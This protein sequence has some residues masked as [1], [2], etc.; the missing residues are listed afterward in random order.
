[1]TYRPGLMTV[2]RPVSGIL[3]AVPSPVQRGGH[4]SERSTW[5]DR[6]GRPSH[7]LT[8]LRVGFAK[9]PGS[10]RALVRS[11]RTVSP[12]PVADNRIRWIRDVSPSAVCF[13]WHF[14]ASHLDWPLASTLPCGVPT[15]LDQVAGVSAAAWPRP[16]GRL[17]VAFIVAPPNGP[18]HHGREPLRR[19]SASEA[20]MALSAVYFS[21][22]F[23]ILSLAALVISIWALVDVL[24]RPDWAFQ[25][26]RQNK[27]L[28][29]VLNIVGLFVCGLVIGL[30]YLLAIRPKVA[31]AQGGGPPGGYGGGQYGGGQPYGGYG[32]P[33][34]GPYGATGQP[35]YGGTAGG[36]YG[37]TGAGQYGTSGPAQYPGGGGAVYGSGQPYQTPSGAAPP[38]PPAAQASPPP[39]WY[40]DPA[41]SGQPRYW[42]G[43]AWA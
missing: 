27:T 30:I 36:Q 28:W 1:M 2:S 22:G 11:Y 43:K 8:L 38:P 6:A 18:W 29:V 34:S 42:D 9:P 10:P 32:G 4:P 12:S 5:G 14:P 16:P 31:A 13:L 37:E 3:S 35:P 24:R 20:Y 7:D 15:F 21:P 19:V 26:A 40:P 17:T 25:A 41:G 33:G 23:L 39:G